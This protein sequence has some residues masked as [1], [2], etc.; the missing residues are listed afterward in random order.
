MK[1]IKGLIPVGP[2][3]KTFINLYTQ[4]AIMLNKLQRTA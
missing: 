2:H 3:R 4:T 1:A